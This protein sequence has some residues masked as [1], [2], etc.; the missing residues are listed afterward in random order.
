MMV[1][2]G[3]RDPEVIAAQIA[4]L[5]KC[6]ARS[7]GEF[8]RGASAALCWLLGDGPGPVTGEVAGRPGTARAIV[9]ELAAAEAVVY[10]T[11]T[12]RTDFARGVEHALM[13]AR[14]VP[15]SSPAGDV[16]GARREENLHRSR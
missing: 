14:F 9:R 8:E 6:M 5:D 13:W 16:S 2:A 12:D 7:A 15:C 1:R 4:A 11:T 10:G 3:L